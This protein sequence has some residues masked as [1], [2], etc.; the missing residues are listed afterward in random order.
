LPVSS[1]LCDS[2]AELR[3]KIQIVGVAHVLFLDEV[4]FKVN[5]VTSHTVVAPG[6][7][8]YVEVEDNT[9]YSARFD[10]IACCTY[11]EVLPP[12]IFSPADR[13][14]MSQSGIN[15]KMLIKYIQDM[16]AQAC[17]ALDRYPLYLVLDRAKIHNKEKILEAFHDNG[18]QELVEVWKMPTKAA[19]RMS[20]L[21]NAL[22]H[23][24]KESIRHG[25]QITKSNIVT[26]MADEWNDLPS[27]LIR[28]QYRHCG[29]LRWHDLYFDCPQ[30]L[31]HLH[32][33]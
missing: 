20:P 21:D 8:P 31:V 24:W 6:Q 29:L 25:E 18:C 2:I 33:S 14:A 5:E 16:L 13:A 11:N 32:S 7:V 12:I 28:S 1:D 26:R 27:S 15:H 23:H 3:R 30:P 17:G 19:K 9:S 4:P 22:F 10:M